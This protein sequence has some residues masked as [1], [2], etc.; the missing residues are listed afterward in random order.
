MLR[1]KVT[2][3]RDVKEGINSMLMKVDGGGHAIAGEEVDRRIKA[4]FNK[5]L[6]GREV[7]ALDER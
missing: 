2:V 4:F 3:T 1:D 7:D 6:L 5:G